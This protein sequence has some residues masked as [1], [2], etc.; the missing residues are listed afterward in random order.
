MQKEDASE[1]R[2]LTE[3]EREEYRKE[4]LYKLIKSLVSE[5]EE[6]YGVIKGD[7]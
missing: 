1:F 3:E 5:Y 6:K 7:I 2:R 4:F